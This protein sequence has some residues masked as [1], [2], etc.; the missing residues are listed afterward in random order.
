[1]LTIDKTWITETDS[2]EEKI[3]IG[4][5]IEKRNPQIYTAR[6]VNLIKGL[7]NKYC[8]GRTEEQKKQLYYVSLYDYWMFGASIDEEIYLHFEDK[9]SEEKREYLTDRNRWD[10]YRYLNKPED[11]HILRNKYEAYQ[12]LKEYYKRDMIELKGEEDRTEFDWFIE[13]HPEFVVKP[14]GGSCAFGVEKLSLKDY[15][16]KD[17]LFCALMQ[18]MERSKDLSRLEQVK[19]LV[20]EELIEQAEELA[21]FHPSSIN[22]I[23]LITIRNGD[24][25]SFF[26]PWIKFGASGS[27]IASAAIDGFD[28]GIDPATGVIITDGFKESGESVE[29]HPDSGIRFKG[30]QIPKWDELLNFARELALKLPTFRYVGWDVVLTP[31]GWCV[32][33]GNHAGQMMGQMIYQKGLRREFEE[34]IHWRPENA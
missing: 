3:R 28:A 14:V 10:Y 21:A 5:E 20:L 30:Y 8:V 17:E 29:C 11:W 12:L 32:M 9:T 18:I 22:A 31:N 27:F 26:Y 7:I 19:S 24:Q 25:V 34:M 1:M 2:K 13:K 6:M 16:G 4:M 23:R 33:E 15:S